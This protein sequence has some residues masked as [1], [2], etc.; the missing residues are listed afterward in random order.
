MAKKGYD[1][2]QPVIHRKEEALLEQL[3]PEL[4]K[5]LEELQGLEKEGEHDRTRKSHASWT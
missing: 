5:K 1:L 2:M 4:A 3:E